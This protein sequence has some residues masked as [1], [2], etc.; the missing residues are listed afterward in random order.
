MKKLLSVISAL[1]LAALAANAQP[2]KLS[3]GVAFEPAADKDGCGIA[4]VVK[5]YT[6]TKNFVDCSGCY[7]FNNAG[8]E[9][10]GVYMWDLPIP[11]INGLHAHVGPGAHLGFV[12]DGSGSY[13]ELKHIEYGIV[14]DLGF[15]YIIPKTPVSLAVDYRPHF[16]NATGGN[17]NL[18]FDLRR[19][20]FGINLCF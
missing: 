13:G 12:T 16:T 14:A 19:L 18:F 10:A 7:Y 15:E 9:F 8:F 11:L 20:R 3:E 17:G 2:Y 1:A 6:G 5:P 4:I